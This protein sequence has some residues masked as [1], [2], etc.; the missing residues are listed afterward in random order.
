MNM[1]TLKELKAMLFAQS[2][3]NNDNLIV[4]NRALFDLELISYSEYVVLREYVLDN[5]LVFYSSSHQK[6]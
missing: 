2:K 6:T 5:N 1:K 3:D 4:N